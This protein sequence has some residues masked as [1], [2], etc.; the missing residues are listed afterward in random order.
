MCQR[1]SGEKAARSTSIGDPDSPLAHP[2]QI[3][4]RKSIRKI[5]GQPAL[6][7]VYNG[8]VAVDGAIVDEI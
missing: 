5:Q 2:A 8:E 6:H 7:P 3:Q 4:C 1:L